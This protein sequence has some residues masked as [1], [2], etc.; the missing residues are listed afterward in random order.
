VKKTILIAVCFVLLIF[1]S[2]CRQEA[3]EKKEIE[4][5]STIITEEQQQTEK[6]PEVEAFSPSFI[7]QP[8]DEQIEQRISGVS[9]RQGSPVSLD[10]LSYVQVAYWGFDYKEHMGELIVHKAVAQEIAEIFE[11]LYEAKFP[12]EKITLIDEY[13]ADDTRSMEDNNTSSFNFREV[14]GKP[15]KLSK[16]AYGLAIDINP[17]QNPYV[18]KEEISPENGKTYT[19]RADARKGMIEKGDACYTAFT[20]RGWTWGGDWKYEKDYQHFQK[21]IVNGK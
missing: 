12:I 18:Y 10:D 17:V 3:A 16:H 2:G 5:K 21:D 19:E 20:S 9:W 8:I 13:G 14:E 6:E 1:L 7:V 15:G 11:E 4:N